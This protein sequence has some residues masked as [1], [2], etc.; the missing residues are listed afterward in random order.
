MVN[1]Q[2]EQWL[3]LILDEL[4]ERLFVFNQKGQIVDAFGQAEGALFGDTQALIGQS[5]NQLLH[6]SKAMML[7][8]VIDETITHQQRQNIQYSLNPLECPTLSIAQI[9]AMHSFDERWFEVKV[10]PLN[11]PNQPAMVIWQEREITAEVEQSQQLEWLAQTDELTGIYNR[12]ALMQHLESAVLN[13]QTKQSALACLMIDIDHFKEINDQVGHLSGDQV[14]QQVATLCQKELGSRD[15]I[16][17]FGGEEFGVILHN[18]TAIEAFH[19]AETLRERV[20]SQPC[21]VDDH[22]I[23]PTVS[24]GIAELSPECTRA[25]DLLVQADK[26]MYYSKKTGRDQVTLYHANLPSLQS[27]NDC[28]ANILKVS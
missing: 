2:K 19:I 4:P 17:R 10:K 6:P 24:I 3:H 22:L 14:I 21:L 28:Q 20:A 13:A 9:D 18:V 16:G 11:T 1:T 25:E 23:Q 15:I 7:Q 5:L 12:R 8:N 27:L 26:A